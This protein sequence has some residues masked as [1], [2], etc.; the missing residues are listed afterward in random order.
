MP[1]PSYVND[2]LVRARSSAFEVGSEGLRAV[3]QRLAVN[4]TRAES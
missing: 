3:G 2:L 4:A 1:C